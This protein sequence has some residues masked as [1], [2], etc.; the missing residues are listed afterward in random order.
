MVKELKANVNGKVVG[1][2]DY[3][4]YLN[5]KHLKGIMPRQGDSSFQYF[6]CYNDIIRN[7]STNRKYANVTKTYSLT[8]KNVKNSAKQIFQP[9]AA[10]IVK[11]INDASEQNN[12]MRYSNGQ[13]IQK[14]LNKL[15]SC[16]ITGLDNAIKK[17]EALSWYVDLDKEKVKKLQQLLVDLGYGPLTVDGIYNEATDA[18]WG[19][20][21]RDLEYGDLT[22]IQIIDAEKFVDNANVVVEMSNQLNQASIVPVLIKKGE[23]VT[24]TAVKE[25]IEKSMGASLAIEIGQKTIIVY[26][27]VLDLLEVGDSI[28]KDLRNFD[29]AISKKTFQKITGKVF[30]WGAFTWSSISLAKKILIVTTSAGSM[31][32][33][34]GAIATFAVVVV[35]TAAAE[36]LGNTAGGLI[37]D[38]GDFIWDYI[39]Y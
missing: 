38:L 28:R 20:F 26:G 39:A 2:Q 30:K 29:T 31:G 21:M 12:F 1:S 15:K 27:A 16:G 11:D 34:V 18:A 19:R 17:A 8:A 10:A 5:D 33:L 9:I 6:N 7:F 13:N 4:N 32:V 35:I 24:T 23:K 25:F 3:F 36:E 14:A 22:Q 37:W